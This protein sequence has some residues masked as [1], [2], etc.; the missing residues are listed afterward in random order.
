MDDSLRQQARRAIELAI[1]LAER[2][3]DHLVPDVVSPVAIGGHP[4]QRHGVPNMVAPVPAV[5]HPCQGGPFLHGH[6]IQ[7]RSGGW[8]A[9]VSVVQPGP[10]PSYPPAS[11]AGGLGQAVPA[12]PAAPGRIEGTVGAGRPARSRSRRRGRS[13]RERDNHERRTAPAMRVQANPNSRQGSRRVEARSHP[14]SSGFRR[15]VGRDAPMARPVF[16]GD[17][18]PEATPAVFHSR[19]ITETRAFS[20]QPQRSRRPRPVRV[21]SG[22]QDRVEVV[23]PELQNLAQPAGLYLRGLQVGISVDSVRRLYETLSSRSATL[24]ALLPQFTL[25]QFPSGAAVVMHPAFGSRI[26]VANVLRELG[27]SGSAV[28]ALPTSVG[29]IE[30]RQAREVQDLIGDSDE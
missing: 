22:S 27:A 3:L 24:N 4:A 19:P 30:V 17:P 28:A 12:V 7:H 18:S 11:C 2:S 9:P 5:G 6:G 20:S 25:R 14:P 21:L 29:Q 13:H 10:P 23:N 16:R 26:V 15:E 1:N 8:T